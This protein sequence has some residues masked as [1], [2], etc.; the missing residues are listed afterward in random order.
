MA[1]KPEFIQC[2]PHCGGEEY[3]IV[4]RVSGKIQENHR[5]DG[6]RADNTEMWD[7]VVQ[8]EQKHRYCL[9]CEKP[10]PK[11]AKYKPMGNDVPEQW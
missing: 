8:K 7:T 3:F 4:L 9:D 5:F 1:D 10:L 6:R 11:D 2:C